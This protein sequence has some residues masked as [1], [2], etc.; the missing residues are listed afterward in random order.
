L[1][2]SK[3]ATKQRYKE[4]QM[5]ISEPIETS[6]YEYT[7]DPSNAVVTYEQSSVYQKGDKVNQLG[8]T[9]RA[10]VDNLT[11]YTSITPRD[12]LVL[13]ID[14]NFVN[15]VYCEPGYTK[16]FPKFNKYWVLN[17]DGKIRLV[18]WGHGF[19]LWNYAFPDNLSGYY[20]PDAY[21]EINFPPAG[22]TSYKKFRTSGSDVIIEEY[23]NGDGTS[24]ENPGTVSSTTTISKATFAYQYAGH[25][26]FDDMGNF[27]STLGGEWEDDTDTVL[28]YFTQVQFGGS[29]NIAD[30]TRWEPLPIYEPQ[31][32]LDAKNYTGLSAKLNCKFTV[33]GLAP[34]DTLAIAGLKAETITVK[35]M[36]P[37]GT[38]IHEIVHYDIDNRRDVRGE[39]SHYPSTVV[40]YCPHDNPERMTQVVPEGGRVE[41]IF[42]GQ[43]IFVG[44]IQLGLAFDIGIT[45]FNF[46]TSFV[47]YSPVEVIFNVVH[48]KEGL[49]VKD[50]KGSFRFW[51]AHFDVH[52]RLFV[53]LGGKL[54]IIN[55]SDTLDN[56]VVD[57]KDRF[58][59]TMM[60]GRIKS[61]PLKTVKVDERMG[62]LAEA[63]FTI[64]EIV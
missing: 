14:E 21:G 1:F 2:K 47:D 44:T 15:Y 40:L 30:D 25:I 27:I 41:I 35:F 39:A 22:T 60:L 62:T 37:D 51:T 24:M 36:W 6:L 16:Y 59:A 4:K 33:E 32:V 64:R 55:G 26:F 9:Y 43:E 29:G 17:I 61:M 8:T 5:T 10:K 3:L 12:L 52:D 38:V 31:L 18:T 20:H 34:F 56:C 53:S 28:S 45:N 48:Y 11:T 58:A 49:K 19:M 7:E 23:H 46:T 42:Y 57:S 54:V 13:D 50:Y 63:S